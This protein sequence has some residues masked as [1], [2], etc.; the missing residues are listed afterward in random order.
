M[1]RLCRRMADVGRLTP[2][3]IIRAAGFGRMRLLTHALSAL[4]GVSPEKASLMIHDGG[5]FG[6]KA[7]C[8]RSNLNPAQTKIIR[9]A[10]TIFRDLEQGGAEYDQTNFQSIMIQRMLTLPLSLPEKEQDW[11]LERLDGLESKVA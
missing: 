2:S 7:L 6:L 3:F 5:P 10:C 9:A 11:F 4:S 8:A 1:R